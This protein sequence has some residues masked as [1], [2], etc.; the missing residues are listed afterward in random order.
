MAFRI[1]EEE[2]VKSSFRTYG[3]GHW[4]GVQSP[5]LILALSIPVGSMTLN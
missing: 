4:G 1:M 3:K 5:V 2:T